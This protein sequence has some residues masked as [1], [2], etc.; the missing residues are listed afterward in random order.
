[1]A[2][3]QQL[4]LE[5][6]AKGIKLT[7][8]QLEQLNNTVDDTAE[9]VAEAT[10]SFAAMAAGAYALGS[11][12][13]S[14]IATGM[15]FDK[16]MSGVEAISGATGD[17]FAELRQS[18]LDFGIQSV[19]TATNVAELQFELSKLGFAQEEI[20]NVTEGV[21]NLAAATGE[22]LAYASEIAGGTLRAFQL[23]SSEMNDVVD[24]MAMAFST[25]AL[26]MDRF[27]NSMTY[28]GP[29]A[30]AMGWSMK[31]ATSILSVLANNMI[32]G[33]MAGT[34]FRK[35][36]L[37]V[38]KDGSKMSKMVGFPIKTLDDFKKA[39]TELKKKG[40]D[41][42]TEGADLVGKRAVAAFSVL[43]NNIDKLGDSRSV[44]DDVTGA[45]KE[46]ADTMI[47]N[48]AGDMVILGA[49]VDNVSI[50]FSD[51][52]KPALREITQFMTDWLNTI[53]PGDL[54]A[55]AI[56]IGGATTAIGFMN[57]K[58]IMTRWAAIKGTIALK[59]MR[60]AMTSTGWG[61][62]AVALGSIIG[63]LLDWFNI[64]GDNEDALGDLNDEIGNTVKQHSK[65][66]K[67]VNEVSDAYKDYE[68]ELGKIQGSFNLDKLI[69]KVDKTKLNN[70]KSELNGLN[71]EL[72]NSNTK[73][74]QF[75]EDIFDL[76][77]SG[78]DK[79]LR[80]FNRIFK[81]DDTNDL[82]NV[83]DV[84]NN[85]KD[86]LDEF[87]QITT[88][89]NKELLKMGLFINNGGDYLSRN[90]I[91]YEG[92]KREVGDIIKLQGDKQWQDKSAYEIQ[93]DTNDLI[94]RLAYTYGF[95]IDQV[96]HLIRNHDQLGVFLNEEGNIIQQNL[97][98]EVDNNKI[99][100]QRI[101]DKKEEIEL[102]QS[103]VE[104]A[105]MR[106]NIA[107]KI[108]EAVDNEKIT[109]DNINEI[110]VKMLQKRSEERSQQAIKLQ[111]LAYEQ[112]LIQQ[113]TEENTKAISARL[114]DGETYQQ[115]LQDL[116]P[117]LEK[118]LTLEQ[119]RAEWVKKQTENINKNINAK[120][121]AS[122][123][124]K[125]FIDEN[126]KLV[127][128]FTQKEIDLI[129]SK[130]DAGLEYADAVKKALEEVRGVEI[131]TTEKNE[132]ELEAMAENLEMIEDYT[133]QAGDM[134][135]QFTDANIERYKEE[136]QEKIEALN[137]QE[138][139]ELENL[140]KSNQYRRASDKDKEKMEKDIQTKFAKLREKE[141]EETNARLK[142][143]F[144]KG[145]HIKRVQ[146]IMATAQAIMEAVKENPMGG[147][148]PG[149]A[150]AA[151]MG[152]AQLAMIDQQKAPT[153][154]LGG[155]IGG[156]EH[157]M[158]GTPVIAERGEFIMNRDAVENMGIE[159]MDR[160]NT[161]GGESVVVNIS[162][163]VLSD[164]FIS[165]EAIPKIKEQ[166]RRGEDLGI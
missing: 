6:K 149:S 90:K 79:V 89:G 51:G 114:A 42:A 3:K 121:F 43:F 131:F 84:L 142:R 152:A 2:T 141:E 105:D 125:Q 146:T 7:K 91:E 80:R 109:M 140:K 117:E 135:M 164:D 50:Q 154:A 74:D 24:T 144:K 129:A 107:N 57:K 82:L 104:A 132:T 143:E 17:K 75:R 8:S 40:F 96:L 116:Y 127:T 71:T 122:E 62:L 65:E 155:L 14:V 18:A 59:G 49:A 5:L 145:Q 83:Q 81:I 130:M 88:G 52:L 33:S 100:K 38:G 20:L 138:K 112:G 9:G 55:Y 161:G 86:D 158:G 60:A 133:Q 72:G 99:I 44:L 108:N 119:Q 48:L 22:D 10:G 101:D 162:G 15:E 31:D 123:K 1:V 95:S 21:L 159:A 147:G 30:N 102:E 67:I 47:D 53:D 94:E 151:V 69:E 98:L 77:E 118:T 66:K 23:D 126:D 165:E 148:L 92:I 64:V 166:L 54:K 85:M 28:V 97:K 11:A 70:L 32:H 110:Y 26:N 46:M 128:Q 45:T 139:A 124:E 68:E 41:P 87:V 76:V 36:L 137:V 78:D 115:I 111:L 25:S 35:I 39:L 163:N 34:S 29:V 16:T 136:A 58:L 113:I 12:L 103:L 4:I 19:Y 106:I 156:S 134:M 37:D 160:I 27:A 56:G 157:S 120:I 150:F 63:A 153:M 73:I 61:A 13:Q 93:Q